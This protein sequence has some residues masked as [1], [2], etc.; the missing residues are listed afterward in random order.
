[1]LPNNALTKEQLETAVT[2][3][4]Q[5][6]KFQLEYGHK[7]YS[8][9]QPEIQRLFAAEVWQPGVDIQ[10]ATTSVCGQIAALLK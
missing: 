9:L 1:M 4:M 5:S 10:K 8:A 7:N 3:A 6:E 2:P